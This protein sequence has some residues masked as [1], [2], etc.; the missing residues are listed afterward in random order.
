MA[1]PTT[2]LGKRLAVVMEKAGKSQSSLAKETGV[3]QATIGLI[4]SG[5]VKNSKSDTIAKLARAL[6]VPISWLATGY[7]EDESAAEKDKYFKCSP[8]GFYQSQ[9]FWDAEH[10][11]Y[12]FMPDKSRGQFIFPTEFM[13]DRKLD[14]ERCKI[15]EVNT[16]AM[17]PA[18][19][20]GDFVL[21]NCADKN[22][23]KENQQK[24]Y[25]VIVDGIFGF[26]RVSM[27]FGSVWLRYTNPSY[28]DKEYSNDTF[29]S[30]VVVAGAVVYKFGDMGL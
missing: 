5:K 9:A 11:K 10:S 8:V 4:L 26:V 6:N 1:Q 2:E 17:S 13:A 15:F 18:L 27:L 28:P 7:S 20:K 22:I 12:E 29:M 25:A 30:S 24:I 21:V 16:D 23:D 19:L 3:S 14:A